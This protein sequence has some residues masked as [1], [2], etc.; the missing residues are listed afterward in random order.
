MF[1]TGLGNGNGRFAESF[2]DNAS[3]CIE[4]GHRLVGNCTGEFGID[5]IGLY[6]KRRIAIDFTDSPADTSVTA[7]EIV[8]LA[9]SSERINS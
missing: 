4:H 1:R 5:I 2:H 9:G 8:S 6:G 3:L 7:W